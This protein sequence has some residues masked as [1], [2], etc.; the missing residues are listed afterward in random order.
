MGE[1]TLDINCRAEH[2]SQP[3]GPLLS[4]TFQRPLYFQHILDVSAGTRTKLIVLKL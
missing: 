3:A 4:I 2:N 1:R